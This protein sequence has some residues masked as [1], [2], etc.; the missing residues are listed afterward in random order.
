MGDPGASCGSL[1]A[2]RL[3]PGQRLK[4]LVAEHQLSWLTV[5]GRV[6]LPKLSAT[7]QEGFE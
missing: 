4:R 2:Q 3:D 6:G 1:F 5:V 7:M